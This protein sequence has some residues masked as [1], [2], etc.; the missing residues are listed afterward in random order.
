MKT[1]FLILIALFMTFI[2]NAQKK[3]D[4]S[5]KIWKPKSFCEIPDS[6]YLADRVFAM[7]SEWKEEKC[8]EIDKAGNLT[9]VWLTFNNVKKCKLLFKTNFENFKLIKKSNGKTI[10]P[11]A[12]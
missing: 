6:I 2:T 3:T 4:I 9:G 10:Y 7:H 12:I 11:Y 5:C 8:E 1:T